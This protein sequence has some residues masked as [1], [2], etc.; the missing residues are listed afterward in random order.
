[1]EA[2]PAHSLV[3]LAR[4]VAPFASSDSHDLAHVRTYTGSV[5]TYGQFA[6]GCGWEAF[7]ALF[8][9]C[10]RFTAVYDTFSG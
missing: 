2:L 9:P 1:M 10:F 8:P 4:S 5:P 6:E 7:R 3:Q